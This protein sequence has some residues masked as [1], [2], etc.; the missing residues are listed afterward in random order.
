MILY[1]GTPLESGEKIIKE[2][3]IQCQI[4]RSHEGY[5]NIIEGTTDGYVYLTRNLQTAYYY[6]NISL[7]DQDD[8]NKNYV[9][10][11]KIEITDDKDLLEPDF[12]E[13]K[14]RSK[15]NFQNITWK[16]SLALCGCVRI[17][18]D[19]TIKELEYIKLPGT[20]NMYEDT[21][22]VEICRKLSSMQIQDE[23]MNKEMEKEIE[24]RWKWNKI[25]G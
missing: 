15:G 14:V 21:S 22:D 5:K 25:N 17:K 6:G 10:I 12:D 7:L 4:Q 18:Q 20:W 11:F 1:H 23:K 24:T 3:K 2:G 16:E 9:Y 8:W 19:I 13:L